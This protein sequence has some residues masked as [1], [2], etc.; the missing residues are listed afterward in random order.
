MIT[1]LWRDNGTDVK[2][3]RELALSRDRELTADLRVCR[4]RHE[5]SDN[6]CQFHLTFATHGQKTTEPSITEFLEV[7]KGVQAGGG[8]FLKLLEK[9][10]TVRL[11]HFL[12][13]LEQG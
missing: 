11:V 1:L 2:S 3:F 8:R 4:E 10:V 9:P 6:D 12:H 5:A 13:V 7:G